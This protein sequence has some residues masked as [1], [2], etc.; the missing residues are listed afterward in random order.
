MLR[1]SKLL[2]HML[3]YAGYLPLFFRI[4]MLMFSR[5]FR[6]PRC[7]RRFITPALLCYYA[8]APSL[9]S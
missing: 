6:L 8:R 2:L 5:Y 1:L 4:L 3:I 9:M 7:F